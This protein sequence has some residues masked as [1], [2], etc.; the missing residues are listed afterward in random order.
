MTVQRLFSW[1]KMYFERPSSSP[2]LTSNNDTHLAKQRW[3]SQDVLRKYTCFH[4]QRQQRYR[5]STHK[6][7]THT[8]MANSMRHCIANSKS[9]ITWTPRYRCN[10][11]HCSMSRLALYMHV[12]THRYRTQRSC[13]RIPGRNCSPP[14]DIRVASPPR[15]WTQLVESP[16]SVLDFSP[17]LERTRTVLFTILYNCKRFVSTTPTQTTLA[18]SLIDHTFLRFL[19]LELF[20]SARLLW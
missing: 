2:A 14:F 12:Q 18:V 13:G 20:V 6:T 1:Q 3:F 11:L 19:A 4:T 10:F 8:R 17:S 7:H 5:T 9:Q 15:K 16:W